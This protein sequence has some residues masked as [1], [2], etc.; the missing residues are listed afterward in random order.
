MLKETND[1][2]IIMTVA[3]LLRKNRKDWW[4][5]FDGGTKS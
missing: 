5:G 4:D 1:P 2:E 3:K